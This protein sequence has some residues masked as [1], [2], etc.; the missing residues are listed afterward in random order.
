[1][2]NYCANVWSNLVE[3]QQEKCEVASQWLEDHHWTYYTQGRAIFKGFPFAVISAIAGAYLFN[4]AK[5]S[6][7]AIFGAANYMILTTLIETILM[8]DPSSDY[9]AVKGLGLTGLSGVI[10]LAFIRTVCKTEM[11]Y[12]TACILTTAAFVGQLARDFL[13]DSDMIYGQ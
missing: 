5:P 7:G 2:I 9:R 10:S 11:T 8:H 6:T 4:C 13:M 12:Q 3:F 1:M